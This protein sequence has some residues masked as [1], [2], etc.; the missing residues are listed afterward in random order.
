MNR[1]S[2]AAALGMAVIL[3]AGCAPKAVKTISFG[4]DT[5]AKRVLIATEQS[6]FKDAVI[7]SVTGALDPAT[8][9]VK[10]IDIKRLSAEA[11]ASYDAV[12]LINTVYAWQMNKQAAAFLKNDTA[13]QRVIL[14]STANGEDWEAGIDGVDAITSASEAAKVPAVSA[15]VSARLQR[16][17]ATPN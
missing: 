3:A 9:H 1:K 12:I 15:A 10:V 2:I 14:L 4:T 6:D 13:R 17:L 16:I 5:A 8:V 11:P 7:S